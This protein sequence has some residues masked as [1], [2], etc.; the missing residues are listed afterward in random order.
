MNAK[1]TSLIKKRTHPAVL[2]F[3]IIQLALVCAFSYLGSELLLSSGNTLYSNAN[4]IASKRMMTMLLVG[5]DDFLL[6]RA[7]LAQNHLNLGVYQGFQK[8]SFRKS[9]VPA[10][11]KFSLRLSANSYVNMLV[12]ETESGF[13]SLRLSTH[14]DFPSA[15]MDVNAKGHAKV[16]LPLPQLKSNE[17]IN[18]QQ[19]TEALFQQRG[20]MVS[21][22]TD[23]FASAN[24]D[25]QLPE[26]SRSLHGHVGFWGGSSPAEI[27]N[28]E[29]RDEGGTTYRESFSPPGRF[30]PLFAA[31]FVLSSFTVAIATSIVRKIGKRDGFANANLFFSGPPAFLLLLGSLLGILVLIILFLFDWF[32][33]SSLPLNPRTKLLNQADRSGIILTLE[34]T[35]ISA[36]TPLLEFAG[37]K[38]P[39]HEGIGSQ[40]YPLRRI[41]QG[42]V[43]CRQGIVTDLQNCSVIEFENLDFIRPGGRKTYRIL[44]SGSSQ[45][46]GAGASIL[47]NSFFALVH[48]R[49]AGKLKIPLE[50]L[51]IAVSADNS[52]NQ[53]QTYTEKYGKFQ[54][55]MMVLNWSFNDTPESLRNGLLKFIRSNQENGIRTVLVAEASSSEHSSSVEANREIVRELAKRFQLPLIEPSPTL[56]Q[57]RD[58]IFWDE[59]HLTDF[60]QDL[61]AEILSEQLLP[62]ILREP[63]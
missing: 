55:N 46:I 21:L 52:E 27:D 49:L 33:W 36:T 59:V 30:F 41:W 28:I 54:P 32:Y 3:F 40:G 51:N 17:E 26:G 48:E 7:A 25:F 45:T 5:A 35:R 20:G 2:N 44:F 9:L 22:K 58:F 8:V 18:S 13:Y 4:W 23:L 38:R 42:P 10:E 43:Y 16:L 31:L 47:E 34:K 39:T 29:I 60:G 15:F 37:V 6:D 14:P 61:M 12:G 57:K 19:W 24:F 62:L 50:S 1:K 11:I 56:N 53:A 63:Q